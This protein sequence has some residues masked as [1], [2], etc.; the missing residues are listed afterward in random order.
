LNLKLLKALK[1]LKVKLMAMLPHQL[2]ANHKPLS[3]NHYTASQHYAWDAFFIFTKKTCP[4][5]LSK[6]VNKSLWTS[7]LLSV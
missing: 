3:T 1:V 7:S 2:K 4:F 6:T 5:G